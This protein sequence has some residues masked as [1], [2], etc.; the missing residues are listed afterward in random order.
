[1]RWRRKKNLGEEEQEQKSNLGRNMA[2][3]RKVRSAETAA[4]LSLFTPLLSLCRKRVEKE[5][6]KYQQLNIFCLIDY[7]FGVVGLLLFAL[8]SRHHPKLQD[9]R[10]PLFFYSSL[11]PTPFFSSVSCS[12]W[13]SLLDSVSGEEAHRCRGI[14]SGDGGDGDDPYESSSSCCWNIFVQELAL[15]LQARPSSGQPNRSRW[16]DLPSPVNFLSSQERIYRRRKRRIWPY[17]CFFLLYDDPIY[18]PPWF[19]TFSTWLFMRAGSLEPSSEVKRIRNFF[20]VASGLG[21][22]ARSNRCDSSDASNRGLSRNC[23]IFFFSFQKY[24]T[25]KLEA[26]AFLAMDILCISNVACFAETA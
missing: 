22:I 24:P 16:S 19:Q 25:L 6:K 10:S 14:G 12:L 13:D 4:W 2:L 23:T 5:R 17:F 3:S 15:I 11:S 9:W 1:M 21:L 26:I 18:H 20:Y 8:L 7:F